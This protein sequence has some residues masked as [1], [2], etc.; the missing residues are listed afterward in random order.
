MQ[1]E[2][3]LKDRK[4]YFH[5]VKN[6]TRSTILLEGGGTI[7]TILH[8]D[9]GATNGVIHIIDRVLGVEHQTIYEKLKTDPLL[10]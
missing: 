2:S 8:T 3:Q 1:V 5:V 9:I 6:Q 10:K 7:A 4:L